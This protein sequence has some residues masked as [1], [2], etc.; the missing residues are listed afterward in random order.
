MEQLA[1]RAMEAANAMGI[2]RSH[3]YELIRSGELP[4][5]R[6]GKA[7]RI[8][9]SAL[10]AWIERNQSEGNPESSQSGRKP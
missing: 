9:V 10:R 5:V 2:G 1:I 3:V 7:I 4:S 8:P 6:L